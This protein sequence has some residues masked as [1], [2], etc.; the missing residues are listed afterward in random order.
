MSRSAARPESLL[1]RMVTPPVDRTRRGVE[2]PADQCLR[3]LSIYV[4]DR[5]FAPPAAATGPAIGNQMTLAGWQRTDGCAA[6]K[7]RK[8]LDYFQL[9]P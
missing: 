8:M 3:R 4:A 1:A 6:L 2:M 7:P 9:P 5:V